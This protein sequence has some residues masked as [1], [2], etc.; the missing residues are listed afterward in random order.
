MLYTLN[1]Y[2]GVC[3]LYINKTGNKTKQKAFTGHLVST[4]APCQVIRTCRLSEI[5]KYINHTHAGVK[6]YDSTQGTG[7]ITSDAKGRKR[8]DEKPNLSQ[9]HFLMGLGGKQG[10]NLALLEQRQPK[11]LQPKT[12]LFLNADEFTTC[13][14][15]KC[16]S[17]G[18]DILGPA[19]RKRT[20]QQEKWLKPQTGEFTGKKNSPVKLHLTHN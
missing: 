13:C 12:E 5:N 16:E 4:K 6:S 20:V 9:L 17:R 3:Q 18:K 14:P 11:G 8:D 1:L 7:G 2:N 10:P 15:E 19:V